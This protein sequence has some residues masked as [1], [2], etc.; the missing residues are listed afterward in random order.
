MTERFCFS[1]RISNSVFWQEHAR[2]VD[3]EDLVYVTWAERLAQI[4]SG[5]SMTTS[6]DR[7]FLQ[8]QLRSTIASSS[9]LKSESNELGCSPD[10]RSR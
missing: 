7:F 3:S 5:D 6:T 9:V 1:T 8:V 10:P 2:K 4:T